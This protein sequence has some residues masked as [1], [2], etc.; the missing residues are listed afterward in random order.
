MAIILFDTERSHNG[1]LPLTF[2]KAVAALRCGIFT[3]QERWEKITNNKVYIHSKKYLK[4]LYASIP[5]EPNIWIDASVLPDIGLVEKVLSLNSGDYILNNDG[6]IAGKPD[7]DINSFDPE[8]PLAYFTQEIKYGGLER[9]ERPWHIVQNNNEMLFFDFTF[10]KQ[11]KN[12]NLIPS[13]NKVIEGYSIFIEEGAK[14]E[15]CWLNSSSGPIFIGKDA[16]IMEG[17]M[18][19]G[20]LAVCEGAVVKMGSKIYGT[21][22]IGPYSTVCGEIKNSV[23]NGYSNKAHD[24][25][26]GDSVIGEWCNLGAGT[27]NSNIKNTGGDIFAWS[28]AS[29]SF[30]KVGRKCGVIMGDYCFTAINTLINTGSVIGIGCNLFGE[31]LTPQLI[32]CFTWGY[33]QLKVYNINKLRPH[34][35]NWRKMKG[36]K[37]TNAEL[38][39]LNYIFEKYSMV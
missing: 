34:V 25:Y 35:I 15:H 39:I 33:N 29:E 4:E 37:I 36:N 21:T 6:F 14:V 19:R 30:E 12:L 26:L 13:S 1:L 10:F 2:T 3:Q 22:T 20:P 9:L 38:E 27:T 17:S 7:D 18:L 8:N 11:E 23:I 16:T 31:G 32:P 5:L 28:F 24:G